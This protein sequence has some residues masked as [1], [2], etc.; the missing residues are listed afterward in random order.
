[1]YIATSDEKMY[2]AIQLSYNDFISRDF[3][4]FELVL[5]RKILPEFYLQAYL[6]NLFFIDSKYH[7]LY[8]HN[9]RYLLNTSTS[10]TLYLMAY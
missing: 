8:T 9:V 10:L 5:D 6:G 3:T 4:W 2:K 1:M 7:N